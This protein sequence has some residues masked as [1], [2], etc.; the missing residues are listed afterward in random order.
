MRKK[1]IYITIIISFCFIIT[2][3]I[4]GYY[5]V[6][7]KR[8]DIE[9]H[10]LILR[11]GERMGIK[12]LADSADRLYLYNTERSRNALIKLLDS[13]NSDKAFLVVDNVIRY[14]DKRNIPKILNLLN[15]DKLDYNQKLFI[16]DLILDHYDCTILD[17]VNDYM[18]DGNN[19]EMLIKLNN[20]L[21]NL[22]K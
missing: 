13:K 9:Y 16:M 18:R 2:S 17:I 15:D 12:V 22:C 8:L 21:N 1:S 5:D 11:Y 6:I 4:F 3:F 14:K 10:I 20:N 19:T 7:Q